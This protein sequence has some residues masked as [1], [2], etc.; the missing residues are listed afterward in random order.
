MKR[1]FTSWRPIL[2]IAL[3][4]VLSLPALADRWV[5]LGERH[6]EPGGDHDTIHVGEMK[7]EFDALRIVVKNASARI[8]RMVITYENGRKKEL[9]FEDRIHPGETRD[10]PLHGR[11]RGIERVDFWYESASREHRRSLVR[12]YGRR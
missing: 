2:V 10:I 11:Y 5:F 6:A 4:S 3:F 8:H 12:L 7:G 1:F 9:S